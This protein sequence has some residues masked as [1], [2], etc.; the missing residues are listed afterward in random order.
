MHGR[1][2]VGVED[3]THCLQQSP[4]FIT[5]CCSSPESLITACHSSL[6]PPCLTSLPQPP[7]TSLFCLPLPPSSLTSLSNLPLQPSSPTSLSRLPL[8]PPPVRTHT[9]PT[10]E[11]VGEE[12]LTHCL[13]LRELKGRPFS[14]ASSHRYLS[15]RFYAG[16]PPPPTCF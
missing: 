16:S 7:H 2:A 5:T 11:A 13:E 12:D 6:T 1:E 15:A 10:R 4:S 3:L 9:G 14:N 8:P